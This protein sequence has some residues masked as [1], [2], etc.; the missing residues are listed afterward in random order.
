MHPAR[1][2][3]S[4]L[5]CLPAFACAAADAPAKPGN[6]LDVYATPGERVDIGGGRHLDLRCSGE[7][8]PTVVL[9]AGFGADSMAWAKLQPLLAAHV[10]TC[11]YDRAGYGFSDAGPLPRDLDAEVADLHALI[12]AARMA[13]P[14][15]LVGHSIGS[16]LARRYDQRHPDDVAALVLVDPPPQG[17]AE[18]AP[19]YAKADAAMAPAMLQAYRACE[20][21]AK[22]GSLGS[23]KPPRELQGC[24]RPPNP[25]WSERLNAAVRASKSSPAFWQTILSA[26]EAKIGLFDAPVPADETHGD[27]PLVVVTATDAY[28][29]A[30][31]ADRKALQAAQERTHAALAATSTAGRRVEVAGT[32]HDVQLDAPGKVADAVLSV[33]SR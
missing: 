13:T 8:A 33:L 6:D 18:T 4:L 5:A 17:L 2:A 29:D 19:D 9:E 11:A 22:E 1:L 12:H 21:G 31:P 3:A 32:S 23:P 14:V 24:L 15:V 20:Q 28:D 25:A 26:S 30:E 27:K 10:R 16:N 7:G